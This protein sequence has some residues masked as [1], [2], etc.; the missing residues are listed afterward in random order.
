MGYAIRT[1]AWRYIEWYKWDHATLRP[2]CCNS[3][4][5]GGGMIAR[6]LYPHTGDTGM[7]FDSSFE[8]VNVAETADPKAVALMHELLYQRFPK[9]FASCTIAPASCLLRPG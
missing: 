5:T 7:D 4:S 2:D 1:E 6:E 9:A 3:S 8:T